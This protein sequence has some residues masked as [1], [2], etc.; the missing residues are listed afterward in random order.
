MIELRGVSVR[1]PGATAD[2]LHDCSCVFPPGSITAIMGAN[3]SGKSTLARVLTGLLAVD[4]G[5]VL[6]DD[7]RMTAP[8]AIPLLR[9]TVGLVFQRPHQQITSVS[10]ERELAFG[11]ENLGLPPEEIRRRVEEALTTF[12]LTHLRDEL[13][14]S[15]AGGELQRVAVASVLIMAPRYLVLDEPTSFLSPTS[16]RMVLDL[17]ARHRTEHGTGILVITQFPEEALQAEHL[18]LLHEG[19]LAREGP[20]GELFADTHGMDALGIR[21]PRS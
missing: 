5:E 13:P 10:V 9:R 12:G 20:P 16:R 2:A 19:Q 15:L 11:P 18:L 7:V 4:R 21:V 8:G 14:G 3:G 1:Y 6:L 17:A